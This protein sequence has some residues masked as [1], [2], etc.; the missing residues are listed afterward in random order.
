MCKNEAMSSSSAT[1]ADRTV[2]FTKDALSARQT[3]VR[4][5]VTGVLAFAGTTVGWFVISQT[6]FPAF[7]NSFVLR[8]LTT[9]A[10]AI[11]VIL[12]GLACYW[13]IYPARW[14][15]TTRGTSTST[16]TSRS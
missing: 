15:R 11:L 5:V 16:G 4:L 10:I 7:T 9:A 8:G 14:M 1:K 3:L 2:P 12:T 6:N 13:W